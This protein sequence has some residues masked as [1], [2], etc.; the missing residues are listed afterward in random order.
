MFA[1][2]SLRNWFFRVFVFRRYVTSVNGGKIAVHHR[3]DVIL[4]NARIITDGGNLLIGITYG[5]ID[6]GGVSSR[7][8]I[9]KIHLFDGGLF[10][11][12]NVS[13]YAGVVINTIGGNVHIGNGTKINAFAKIIALNEVRIGENCMIAQNVLIRDNDGHKFFD[14]HKFEHKIIPVNIGNKVWIGQNAIILKGSSIGDGA[15]IAAGAVV[16]GEVAPNSVV[17]GIPAKTIKN[18]IQWEA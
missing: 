1:F 5:F 3:A 14:G 11:S 4:R 7:S 16:S 8:D 13:L 18:N 15:V 9:C 2:A 12:G 10:T 17:G 6:G